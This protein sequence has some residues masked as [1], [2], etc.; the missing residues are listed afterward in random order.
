MEIAEYRNIFENEET[1][2]YYVGT[3]SAVIEFLNKYLPKKTGN[4]I[5]DAGCGTGSLMKKL[6]RFG[7]IC[8][9]D[10]SNEALKFAKNNGLRQVRKGSVTNIPFKEN[11]FDAVVSIDVLYHKQVKNDL[12]AL[13]EFR[14]VLK[15]GGILIIKNPAH[16][17]LRGNHDIVIHTKK[18]YSKSEFREKLKRTGFQILKLS[19]IN[20][21][22][23]PLAIAKR[24]AES[25]FKAKPSSDVKNIHPQINKILINIYNFETKLLIKGTIPIGLSLFA[26]A[27]KPT[28]S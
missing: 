11:E 15:P 2:F 8:G 6:K 19:Y 24:L 10:I 16:N 28:K 22:F 21:F 12:Q 23:F 7:E 18:R 17:W 5:L 25:L 13:E 1:H 14:R 3:H 27:K 4:K 9:I 20:I 26:I